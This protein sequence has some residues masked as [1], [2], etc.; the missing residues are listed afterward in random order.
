[1]LKLCIDMRNNL[2]RSFCNERIIMIAF[3]TR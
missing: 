2:D 3:S 1:M